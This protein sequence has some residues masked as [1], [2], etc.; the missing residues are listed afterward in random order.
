MRSVALRLLKQW[1]L[2]C[3]Q[4]P[5]AMLTQLTANLVGDNI[6]KAAVLMPAP[7]TACTSFQRTLENWAYAAFVSGCA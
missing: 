3:R 1:L 6:T 7:A 5:V 4:L 2:L